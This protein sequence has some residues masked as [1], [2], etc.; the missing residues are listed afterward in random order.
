MVFDSTSTNLV[1]ADSNH[2]TD[3]FVRDRTAATTERASAAPNGAQGNGP[4]LSGSFSGDGRLLVFASSASN[5]VADDSNGV[6]DVFARDL[7]VALPPPPPSC[8][9]DVATIIGTPG[10]DTLIGTP[11]RD[12]VLAGSGN[13]TIRTGGGDDV[14]CAGNG[15]DTIDAG[16]GDDVVQGGFGADHVVGGDGADQLFGRWGTDTLAGGHGDDLMKGGQGQRCPGRRRRLRR[17][18]RRLRHRHGRL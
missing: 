18:P 12:V 8:G 13:D 15:D 17:L 3:V 5:L 2:T 16:A 11:G 14:I 7:T 10:D 6:F 9:A 1:A 4:S